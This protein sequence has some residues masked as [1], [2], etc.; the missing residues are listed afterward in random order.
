MIEPFT[1]MLSGGHP[2]SLGRTREV[3]EHVLKAPER[4]HELLNAYDDTDPVVRLRVSSAFKRI[5]QGNHTLMVEH[6]DAFLDKVIELPHVGAQ[7]S[8][9]WTVAQICLALTKDLSKAQY[10][11]VKTH[12]M[13]NL[14]TINDWIV[15]AQTMETLSGWA[16]NDLGLAKWLRP[17]LKLRVADPRPAVSK[18]AGKSLQQVENALAKQRS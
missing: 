3:V 14:E 11:R 2:N 1:H 5:V 4:V 13:S 7:P 12:L 8:A 6:L 10:E 9:Q 17:R 16:V 18:K 15:L